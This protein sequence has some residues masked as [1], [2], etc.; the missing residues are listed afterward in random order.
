MSPRDTT[1][2]PL[3]AALLWPPGSGKFRLLAGLVLALFAVYDSIDLAVAVARVWPAG[4]GDSFALWRFGRFLRGHAAAAIYDPGELRAV[5]LAL[6]MDP[7]ASYPFPYPPSFLLVV[8]PLGWLPGWLAWLALALVSLALFLWATAG[9]ELAAPALVAAAVAPTTT[10]AILSGQS[11]L[12]AAALFAGGVRLAGRAPVASGIMFGLLTFKPQLGLLVPVALVAARLWRTIAAAIATAVLLIVVTSLL[13]GADIWV[14]WAGFAPV[15][16]R[17]FAGESS[18]IVH[19]MPTVL[20]A[21]LRLG[22]APALAQLA[23]LLATAAAAAIVWV[24]YRG[25]PSELAGAGLLVAALV[26]T[27]YAFVYDMAVLATAIVWFV[28]ERQRAGAALG[29]GE[30]LLLILALIAPVVLAAGTSDFPLAAL[31]LILLLGAI[32]QRW[33]GL[34]SGA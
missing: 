6:G 9:R 3:A 31:T 25:G 32:L 4:F 19:L 22:A 2:A 1:A 30:V 17:Q 27:P 12:L 14:R 15:F 18:E 24:M 8:W 21:L 7:G 26:A 33:R 28:A 23:Q 5:Q 13:F 11:G 29:T 34:R 10:I 16:S 20:P